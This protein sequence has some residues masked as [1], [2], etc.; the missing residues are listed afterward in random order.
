LFSRTRGTYFT[1]ADKDYGDLNELGCAELKM[2]PEELKTK[3]LT[4]L[5]SL[6]LNS[7]EI[8][9]LERNTIDQVIKINHIK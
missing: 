4:I 5:N 9:V 7:K 3:R 2:S 6:K 1:G 8:C